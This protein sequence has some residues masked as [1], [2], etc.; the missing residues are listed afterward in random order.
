MLEKIKAFLDRQTV[1]HATL[2]KV[3]IVFFSFMILYAIIV[4]NLFWDNEVFSTKSYDLLI[5]TRLEQVIQPQMPLINKIKTNEDLNKNT[6]IQK[7]SNILH[8]ILESYDSKVWGYSDLDLK[9]TFSLNTIDSIVIDIEK[10]LFEGQNFEQINNQPFIFTRPVYF[11]GIL[12]GY[13][14]LYTNQ[15][16]SLFTSLQHLSISLAIILLLSAVIVILIWKYL[17]EIQIYL[18]SFSSVIINHKMIESDDSNFIKRKLP[19]LSPVLDRIAYYIKNL[20]QTNSELELARSRIDKIVEGI[21]DGFLGLD[22]QWQCIYANTMAKQLFKNDNFLG[23]ILWEAFP[24]TIGSVTETMLYQTVSQQQSMSW[25]A[26][27]FGS[28]DQY[29]EYFAY[30]FDEGLTVFFRDITDLKRQEIELC[31]L[32]R[33]NLIG[34]LAAGISHEIRNP[35]TTVRGFLQLFQAKPCY[36][37]DKQFFELMISEIDR[38]C[39]IISDFLSLSKIKVDH[40]KYCNIN[41]IVQSVFPLLQADA[42]ANNKQACMNLNET[43]DILIDESEIIQLILNLFRNGLDATDEQGCVTICTLQELKNVVLIIRDT[44]SGIPPEL[45]EKIGTPFFTTK[46]AGTGLGLAISFSIAQR[47]KATVEFDTGTD[48][49][50]FFIKFPLCVD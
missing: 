36:E 3:T 19:E 41:D 33:L 40:A 35:L 2:Y 45:R 13:I 12:T 10:I 16:N 5:E 9:Q 47:N 1:I 31:R 30:P 4:G 21:T 29:Y 44:G 43:M 27:G 15:I 46:D 7:I 6:K 18:E 11:N 22:N 26:I 17:K 42:F 14:W 25:K 48:G 50:T 49:T 39:L 20:E 23:Y 28:S 37:Q 8:P 32:E 34:Q 24:E 38:A